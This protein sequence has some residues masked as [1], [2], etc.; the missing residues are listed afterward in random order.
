MI[1]FVLEIFNHIQ[2]KQLNLF[3]FSFIL[4]LT[5]TENIHKKNKKHP[6]PL[7]FYYTQSVTCLQNNIS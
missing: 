4:F 7:L 1:L 2:I 3:L 6:L 5:I